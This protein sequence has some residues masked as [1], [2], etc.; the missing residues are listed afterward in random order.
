MRFKII[1]YEQKSLK[2]NQTLG[3]VKSLED[4]YKMANVICIQYYL[5]LKNLSIKK[6]ERAREKQRERETEGGRERQIVRVLS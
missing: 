6:T 1:H 3:N 4:I 5:Y 2:K